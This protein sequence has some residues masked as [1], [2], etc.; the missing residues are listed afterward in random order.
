LTAEILKQAI[1]KMTDPEVRRRREQAL[2]AWDRYWRE[3]AAEV[4]RES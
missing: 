3:R 1:R 2:A 4:L